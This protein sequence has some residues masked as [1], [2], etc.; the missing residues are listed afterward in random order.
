MGLAD[1]LG[2]VEFGGCVRQIIGC[3]LCFIIIGPIFIICGLVLMKSAWDDPRSD[4]VDIYNAQAKMW[5]V[6]TRNAF[7]TQY[8]TNMTLGYQQS[9]MTHPF[10]TATIALSAQTNIMPMADAGKD[11]YKY[12]RNQYYQ[13]A[14]P[15]NL[16]NSSYIGQTI[17][18]YVPAPVPTPVL[19]PGLVR[20]ESKMHKHT[21]C[22]HPKKSNFDIFLI[23][24]TNI[25][26]CSFFTFTNFF[27]MC[28]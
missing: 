20:C 28:S 21:D 22:S 11:L 16:A 3:L 12:T 24:Y 8:G 27:C 7:A 23:C 26:I 5:D 15:V 13:G 6:S 2:L 4:K 19:L 25:I 10:H 14:I 17:S 9:K 1:S 18:V